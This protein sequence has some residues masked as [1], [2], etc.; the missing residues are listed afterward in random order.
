MYMYT[1][2]CKRIQHVIRFICEPAF[3]HIRVGS[4]IFVRA[5]NA[6]AASAKRRASTAT[7]GV[8]AMLIGGCQNE[9]VHVCECA[10]CGGCPVS[11]ENCALSY[12]IR[13]LRSR[14]S[15]RSANDEHLPNGIP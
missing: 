10:A 6:E 8:M 7:D 14:A 9:P 12:R 5:L 3:V 15:M 4:G 1:V 11:I 2:D 13:C